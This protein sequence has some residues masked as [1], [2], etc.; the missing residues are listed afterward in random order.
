MTSVLIKYSSISARNLPRCCFVFFESFLESMKVSFEIAPDEPEGVVDH[1]LLVV[2]SCV[3][4]FRCSTV[5][6]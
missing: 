5:R 6:F 3:S 2:N 1:L 4:V